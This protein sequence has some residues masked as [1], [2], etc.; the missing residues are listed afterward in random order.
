MDA[1]AAN[2][3]A[4]ILNQQQGSLCPQVAA[5]LLRSFPEL[6]ESL[7][8]E[9]AYSPIS[10]L[11]EM[12]VERL[13]VLV[14]AILVFQVPSIAD[15]ELRWASGVLPR[16]GITFEHQ[17]A[18]IRCFFEELRRFDVGPSELALSREIE[19]YLLLQ[20]RQVYYSLN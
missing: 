5:R 4:G 10:R 11:S 3:L 7:R 12:A 19:N 13:S 20:V 9:E 2:N 6:A 14:R 1:I 18:L 8:L 17:M 15:G 16:A